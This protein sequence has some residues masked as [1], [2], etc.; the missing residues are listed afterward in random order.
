MVPRSVMQ[1][2]KNRNLRKALCF[3]AVALVLA[4]CT[5]AGPR[6]LLEGKALLDR[7]RCAEAVEK[8]TLATSLMA[9]NAQ[10]FN[11]LGLA[12]HQAGDAAGAVTAYRQALRLDRELFEA[13]YN[14]GCLWL[15]QGK[16]DAA[17][18]EFI[19]CTLR[20]AN[21]FEAWLKLGAAQYR[22]AEFAAA[23]DSFQKALQQSPNH[24]EAL[25]GLGLVA[26]QRRRP[27]D[28]AQ[29]FNAALKEQPSYRPALLN[30][31][32]VL[33]RDL[34][35]PAAAAQ[36][37]REYL[38][39]QPRAADWNTV[40]VALQGLEAKLAPAP[41]VAITNPP[42][43]ITAK[44]NDPKPQATVGPRV[45]VTNPPAQIAAK[46]PEPKPQAIA[47]PHPAI[48][49]PQPQVAA[50][51][52]EPKPPVANAPAPVRSN[53]PPALARPVPAPKPAPVEVVKLPPP[54]VVRAT[55]PPAETASPPN[56]AAPSP[57]VPP[58]S[59]A[60]AAAPKPGKP[61]FITRLNPFHKNPKPVAK[62]TP[63][64]PG[65][66]LNAP[67]GS[68]SPTETDASPLR[69]FPRY[70]YLTP[71]VPPVGDRAAADAAFG[72]GAEAQSAQKLPEAAQ[73]FQQAAQADGSFFEA[74]YSLGRVQ[75]LL[76]DYA[77]ALASW[78]QALVIR[79][80]S[81]DARYMFALTLNAAG[82]AP[83]AAVEAEKILTANPNDV[84]AHLLLGKLYAEELRDKARAR[85]HYQ[86]VL[87]L[88]SR[89]PSATQIR[90]WLVAN[91]A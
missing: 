24:P 16:P 47:V 85:V 70:A 23:G 65:N 31:A 73:A 50:K 81:A 27:R 67:A 5:P 20:R 13:H 55:P 46:N 36:K 90:Y 63:L 17:K 7:G 19:A 69:S 64:P 15:D 37:Y 2:T 91:P 71:A 9:T 58:T 34:N 21:S 51:T 86:R 22:L 1:A 77:H 53:P 89:T 14:L 44:P 28:A 12:Q 76:R 60:A 33:Y 56:N 11:Y 43:Q 83:D 68:N 80:L 75:Y 26:T 38:A 40:N 74:H 72:R 84:R 4:G 41:R 88:D 8:L 18:S 3:V 54:P 48:P 62:P 42:P 78:E 6:A 49:N 32:T 10:A 66:P 25:N 82:Y 52:N 61:G 59:V 39:L 87:E 30:L 35:D 79:P 57:T 29:Y 45:A